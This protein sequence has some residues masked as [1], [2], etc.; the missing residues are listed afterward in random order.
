MEQLDSH[1]PDEDLVEYRGVCLGADGF[2]PVCT[3]SFTSHGAV[4]YP[5]MPGG[6][7]DSSLRREL[8]SEKQER[9]PRKCLSS[10]L[11]CLFCGAAD[12][13][14]DQT[15]SDALPLGH[16]HSP[17]SGLLG[18]RHLLSHAQALMAPPLS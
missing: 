11:C 17:H 3:L 7:G 13:T 1:S 18:G 10:G 6:E 2:A 14:R 9:P 5:W 4:S 15:R 16:T 12:Q 8:L